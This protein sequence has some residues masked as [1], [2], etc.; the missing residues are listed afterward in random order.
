MLNWVLWNRRFPKVALADDRRW[1][2][3]A[4]I[5][6]SSTRSKAAF[7]GDC[8]APAFRCGKTVYHIYR[9]W[10]TLGRSLNRDF[11]FRFPTGAAGDLVARF[12]T[13]LDVTADDLVI[14]VK[15]SIGMT[16]RNSESVLGIDLATKLSRFVAV[17]CSCPLLIRRERTQGQEDVS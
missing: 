9:R 4:L 1:I 11:E 5:Y 10:T 14:L 13:R 2:G 17:S 8:F 15:D 6:L 12:N 16:A 7:N 3:V